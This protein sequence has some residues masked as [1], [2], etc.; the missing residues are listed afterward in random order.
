MTTNNLAQLNLTA[1]KCA[2]HTGSYSYR[3][4]VSIYNQLL[5]DQ[6]NNLAT[7]DMNTVINFK[8][9]F[10]LLAAADSF[11]RDT[12]RNRAQQIVTTMNDDFS[13]YGPNNTIL[14]GG[15]YRSIIN[16]VFVQNAPK[17]D[18]Y[19][20]KFFT[21][22]IPTGPSNI[23]FDFSEIRF[24]PT[25]GP[26]KL[27]AYNDFTQTETKEQA[28]KQFINTSR[29][30]G[31]GGRRTLNIW[32][33]DMSDTRF[34]G[35]S[36][37]PWEPLDAFSGIIANRKIF[38]PEE[39]AGFTAYAM[40]KSFSHHA[41]HFLGLI[42]IF[43]ERDGLTISPNP[44]P[45]FDPTDRS[46]NQR[47]MTDPL[48]NPLFPD[49]MDFTYDAYSAI[50]TSRQVRVMRL[51]IEL[52][53]HNRPNMCICVP[54][55]IIAAE[56]AAEVAS[57]IVC[58]PVCVEKT[59]CEVNCCK[60]DCCG[61]P[62][63]E[64][65]YYTTVCCELVCCEVG[66]L[67]PTLCAHPKKNK[68]CDKCRGSLDNLLLGAAP[69]QVFNRPRLNNLA[70][71]QTDPNVTAGLTGL[72]AQP[73]DVVAQSAFNRTPL[74]SVPNKIK[75]SDLAAV[76]AAT[77][78]TKST[79]PFRQA[80]NP[81]ANV[82]SNQVVSAPQTNLMVAPESFDN[83]P[84]HENHNNVVWSGVEEFPKSF[85]K[86]KS[87][88][89]SKSKKSKK[90]W[91][92]SFEQSN[93]SDF[94]NNDYNNNNFNNKFNHNNF[95]HSGFNHSD[96]NHNDFNHNDFNHNNYNYN[97]TNASWEYTT[98]VHGNIIPPW[99]LMDNSKP[100]LIPASMSPTSAHPE[101]R[102][103]PEIRPI[104]KAQAPVLPNGQCVISNPNP[105]FRPRLQPSDLNPR[106][107]SFGA[108]PT[109]RPTI[110]YG[111]TPNLLSQTGGLVS[112]STSIPSFIYNKSGQR[113][114]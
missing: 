11:N 107:L 13:N 103:V 91:D 92:P 65:V 108:V 102:F 100:A 57:E 113:R 99:E 41:G 47:L 34:M 61:N 15:K 27:A 31:V 105:S 98:D 38:F 78:P 75:R 79:R 50:F 17:R 30:I 89:S 101:C 93:H 19:L 96:F 29:A 114:F 51:M 87:K 2:D 64:K 110:R 80:Q 48:Y 43:D 21:D 76:T 81:R 56:V 7:V 12:A 62:V 3:A 33:V 74:Q 39:Y 36:T 14:N 44:V 24:Y 18:T 112:P 53:R 106:A 71:R 72:T 90:H 22:Q 97:N 73:T 16:Q 63:C 42:H 82:A 32:V 40:F 59:C 5:A 68:G 86:K 70:T 83:T 23:V 109:A 9:V 1:I 35:F 8:V 52:F 66:C 58:V 54:Q 95:D 49:F 46:T 60:T 20:G 55:P 77:T 94:N 28:I 69:D 88:K 67:A 4:N 10:H 104:S 25:S 85:V 26:L 6:A 84:R 111:E 45:T 37:F